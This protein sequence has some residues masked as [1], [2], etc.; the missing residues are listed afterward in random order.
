MSDLWPDSHRNGFALGA[1]G[2]EN[3]DPGAHA[4][5]SGL[6][7]SPHPFPH[8]QKT[9]PASQVE[10]PPPFASAALFAF[11]SPSNSVEA[12]LACD[13]ECGKPAGITSPSTTSGTTDE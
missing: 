3:Q 10:V 13:D 9:Q 7:S 4:D 8:P 12:Q 2:R 5:G 6:G 1:R 11:N